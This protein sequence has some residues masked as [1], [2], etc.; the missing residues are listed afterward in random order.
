MIELNYHN[1][2]EA[3]EDINEKFIIGSPELFSEGQGYISGKALYTYNVVVNIHQPW[4]PKDF[5]FGRYFNYSRQKW[6]S[7]VGNYINQKE[8]EVCKDEVTAWE[9]KGGKKVYNVGFQFS[10]KH[11]HGKTCLL[12]AV[13][14][15]R[16]DNDCPEMTVFVRASEVTKRL[17]MDLLLMQRVGTYVFGT[18]HFELVI[19]FRQM[20]NDD[21]VLIMYD[22]HKPMYRLI[23]ETPAKNWGQASRQQQLLDLLKKINSYKALEDVKY[24]VHRR[25]LK[26][27]RPDLTGGIYPKLLAKDCKL[28]KDSN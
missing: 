10:N 15:R 7:L 11:G 3:W 4:L 27:L 13:F 25:A 1:S 22:A 26:V 28:P 23:T 5:D 9:S 17:A 24:K 19:H 6:V 12:S 2:I 21:F 18:K 8:L 20:F 14:S 16:K